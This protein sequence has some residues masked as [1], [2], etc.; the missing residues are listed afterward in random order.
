MKQIFVI[1]VCF[2]L[3]CFNSGFAQIYTQVTNVK[4]PNN[5]TVQAYSLTSADVSYSSAQ[6]ATIASDLAANYNGAELIEAPSY[7]YNCHA[8]AWHVSEGGSKV[9]I[10]TD[11][12][13]I[14]WTDGSYIEVPES[15]ATKVSYHQSG[16][17]SAVRLNSTWYQSKWGSNALV[18]HY[19]NDVPSI[20]QASMTKKYYIKAPTISGPAIIAQ[21]CQG[22]Y[23]VSMPTG[24]TF[25]SW[26]VTSGLTITSDNGVNGCTVSRA[27]YENHPLTA[28]L[29]CNYLL[30]G[31]SLTVQKEIAL[32][33]NANPFFVYELNCLCGVAQGQAGKQ[34]YFVSSAEPAH[35]ITGYSWT[36]Y[37]PGYQGESSEEWLGSSEHS[38]RS[39]ENDPHYFPT[40]GYYT[41]ELQLTDGCG[42]SGGA[43]MQFYVGPGGSLYSVYP[44][45]SSGRF[46]VKV[47]Q[48]VGASGQSTGAAT[49]ARGNNIVAI[50]I[51]TLSGI[52]L[53][54]L[55]VNLQNESSID[56]SNLADGLYV[57]S[58][59]K[60][61]QV[62]ESKNIVIKK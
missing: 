43:S 55:T 4:T 46:T 22:N 40:E 8:Y 45:P 37:P 7:K 5:S 32:R 52:I 19:P 56:V 61:G 35:L 42:L 30:N 2:V 23:T 24:A 12:E 3:C 49:Q 34:Y 26:S 11:D 28:T 51:R 38:G 54:Q 33:L 10:N 27:S 25:Q 62:V 1:T 16:D 59:I 47:N 48:D 14:Y 60:N 17:H 20:Y 31:Q 57:L 21:T 29:V 6:L 9:W 50:Q 39:T 58:I 36:V 44:N 18:K 15:D 41:I 53:K 13:D